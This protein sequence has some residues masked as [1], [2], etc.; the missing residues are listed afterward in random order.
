MADTRGKAEEL[1]GRVKEAAGDLTDDDDLRRTGKA[2]QTSGK[3]KQAV[4]H[5]KD[6]VEEGIDRIKDKATGS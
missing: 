1:K 4:E 3:A 2:E 5:A 6:K